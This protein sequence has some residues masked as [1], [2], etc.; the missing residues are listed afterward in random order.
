[1]SSKSATEKIEKFGWDP[2]NGVQKAAW[3]N[4]QMNTASLPSVAGVGRLEASGLSLAGLDSQRRGESP[5][6]V[7]F[8]GMDYLVGSNVA[9]Y[10]RPIENINDSRF[11]EG[12]ELRAMFYAVVSQLGLTG[13]RVA[14]AIGLPVEMLAD[15]ARAESTEKLMAKWLVGAHRFTFDG[16]D[17]AVEVVKIRATIAQPLGAWLDWGLGEDGQWIRGAAGRTA[18]ALVIDQ[19]FNT[20]DMFAVEDG[21]PS[22]R[23]T[24]GDDLGMARAAEMIA[25][26]VSRRYD[27]V[28]LTLHQADAQMQRRLNGEAP[29][30]YVHGELQNITPEIDQALNSLAADVLMFIKQRVKNDAAR[31]RIILTGGGALALVGRLQREYPHAEIAPD[32]AMANARGL[33]KLALRSFLG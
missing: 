6:Q 29:A 25:Q 21:K 24:A 22:D 7:S 16:A 14:V 32:P 18:P 1:M 15:K 2:G 3:I 19:G 11:V 28:K 4:G 33:A 13:Q 26:V 20:L 12:A 8:G 10:T 30:V 31:F 17:A 9:A 5:F 23:Y 27:G